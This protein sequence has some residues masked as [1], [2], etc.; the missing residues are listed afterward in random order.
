MCPTLTCTRNARW[1]R[2]R[3]LQRCRKRQWKTQI[4]G[5]RAGDGHGT[6]Y[7]RVVFQSNLPFSRPLQPTDQIGF[8]WHLPKFPC[9]PPRP[10]QP[11]DQDVV[12]REQRAKAAEARIARMQPRPRVKPRRSPNN[13][14]AAQG[15]TTPTSPT[16]KRGTDGCFDPF[17]AQIDGSMV[18]F[19][20]KVT[21]KIG[22]SAH[23]LPCTVSSLS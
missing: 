10:L 4:I 8:K 2:V 17:Q 16:L 5:R 13:E 22:Y 19:L 11:T 7:R 14:V 3:F 9:S 6:I 18:R 23:F 15:T 12:G 20:Y 21:C 1:T